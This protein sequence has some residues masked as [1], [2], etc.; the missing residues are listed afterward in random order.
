MGSKK[1]LD[2]VDPDDGDIIWWLF[3]IFFPH[4]FHPQN[5]IS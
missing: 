3:T 2:N 5:N 1:S 4:V